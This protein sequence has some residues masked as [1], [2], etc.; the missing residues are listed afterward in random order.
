MTGA[1]MKYDYIIVGSGSGGTVLASRLSEDRATKVL[2]IEAGGRNRN[3]L[4][5]IP[6]GFI[7]LLGQKQHYW[8]YDGADEPGI[9]NRPQTLSLIHI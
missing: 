1:G 5:S 3:P 4:I 2:L 8:E 7:K 6:M 9:P